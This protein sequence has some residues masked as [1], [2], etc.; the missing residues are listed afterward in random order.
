[1]KHQGCAQGLRCVNASGFHG[2]AWNENPSK[3]YAWVWIFLCTFSGYA[4]TKDNVVNVFCCLIGKLTMKF[5][6]QIQS[7][8]NT[9]GTEC[10]Q[11]VNWPDVTFKITEKIC[12][13]DYW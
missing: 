2:D 10:G 7:I 11:T 3:I 9:Y 1:M 5:K 12:H 13:Q 6:F 8:D 4:E